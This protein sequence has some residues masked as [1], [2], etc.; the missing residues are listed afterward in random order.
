MDGNAMSGMQIFVKTL[1]TKTITLDVESSDTIENIKQKVQEK[2][3]FAPDMQSLLFAGKVLEDGR[4]LADYNIQKESTVQLRFLTG[5]VTYDSVYASSPPLGATN[6]ANLAPGSTL[7]Q[8]VTGVAAGVYVLSFYAKGTMT[9]EV[10]FVDRAN[11]SLRK[12]SGTV[13]APELEASSIQCVAPTGTVAAA[14]VFSTLAAEEAVLL[15]LVS[16]QRT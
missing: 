5:V 2:E 1:T 8:Q 7:G 12:V 3:G 11:Q 16:F 6:L 15:D 9:F 14:L 4:T 13:T 10:N